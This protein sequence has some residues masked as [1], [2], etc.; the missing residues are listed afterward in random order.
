LTSARKWDAN[1]IEDDAHLIN[2]PTLLIW[3]EDDNVIPVRNGEKL[4]DTILNSRLVVLKDCGHVPPEEK[5]ERFVELV[6]EF[7]RDKKSRAEP[8]DNEQ[9]Q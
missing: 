3:G 1:R 6:A 7:C 9:R 4:Y 2:H 5:P 8:I